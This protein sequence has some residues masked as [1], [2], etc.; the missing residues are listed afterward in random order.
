MQQTLLVQIFR[1]HDDS[2]STD[3]PIRSSPTI[4]DDGTILC[5]T[6]VGFSDQCCQMDSGLDIFNAFIEANVNCHWD[7]KL[8]EAI[9]S[10]K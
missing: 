7:L 9:S 5:P 1:I 10:L 2:G 8:A 6:C 4:S 3:D